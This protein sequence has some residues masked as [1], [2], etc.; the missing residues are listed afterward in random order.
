MDKFNRPVSPGERNIAGYGSLA[1]GAFIVA[2]GAGLFPQALAGAHAPPWVIFA[3]GAVFL[4]AGANILSRDRVPALASELLANLLW[5]LMAAIAAWVAWGGGKGEIYGSGIA[6]AWLINFDGQAMGRF[7]FGAGAIL[8]AAIAAACWW[9][10]FAKLGWRAR[11][12]IV[13]ALALAAGALAL[14]VPAEALRLR[15]G[16]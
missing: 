13:L 1:A 3:A 10:W 14:L 4:L 5:T 15:L 9:R 12:G 8:V 6:L 7:V 11:A 2:V 16:G